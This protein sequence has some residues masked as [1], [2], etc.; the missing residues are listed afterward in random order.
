MYIYKYICLQYSTTY[1]KI[2]IAAKIESIVTFCVKNMDI[3][4]P[5]VNLTPNLVFLKTKSLFKSL[6][7]CLSFIYIDLY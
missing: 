7:L 2:R 3:I 6:R 5:G 1:I 4:F